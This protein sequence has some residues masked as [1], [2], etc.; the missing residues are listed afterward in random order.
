MRPTII[1]IFA[2]ALAGCGG[3][4]MTTPDLAGMQTGPDLAGAHLQSGTYNVSNLTKVSDGCGLMLEGPGNFTMTQVINTGMTTTTPAMLSIGNKCSSDTTITCNPDGYNEGTGTYTTSSTATLT[5]N[6]T[7]TYNNDG[8]NYS[9]MVTTN[10]TFVGMN[11]LQ[12][13]YKD[14]ENNYTNC[15]PQNDPV[16][17]SQ[18]CTSEYTFNLSK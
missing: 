10:I 2:L 7:I 13:D 14:V 11:M 4:D 12:V 16:P 5:F 15:N 18:P 9:K 1:G 8:C 17:T 3:T 6:S